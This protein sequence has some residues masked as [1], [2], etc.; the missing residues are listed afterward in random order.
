MIMKTA[1]SKINKNRN[2]KE[3]GPNST[4][5][6][7]RER[8]VTRAEKQTEN[9]TRSC[10]RAAHL[11]AVF[12]LP[13]TSR[14]RQLGRPPTLYVQLPMSSSG[15][16]PATGTHNT[17]YARPFSCCTKLSTRTLTELFGYLYSDLI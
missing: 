6:K 15:S 4:V 1:G 11:F 3:I 5:R 12:L 7:E 14:A 13:F 8:E 17:R 2:K 10:V 16:L 9:S